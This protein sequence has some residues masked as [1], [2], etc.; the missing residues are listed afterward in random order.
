M[1]KSAVMQS[2]NWIVLGL[3]LAFTGLLAAPA[4]AQMYPG[5]VQVYSN[6]DQYAMVSGHLQVTVDRTSVPVAW[7]YE[8]DEGWE[9]SEDPDGDGLTN[10]EEFDGCT[11]T[12]NGVSGVYSYRFD[13][14]A[15]YLGPGSDPQFYDTDG[16]GISD[17]LEVEAV[18]GTHTSPGL[19]DTDGDEIPDAVEMYA[20]L[21]PCRDGCVY[22]EDD[23]TTKE[24]T[25]SY[26]YNYKV[27]TPS[28]MEDEPHTVTLTVKIVDS[29]TPQM[30]TAWDEEAGEM[31]EIGPK[32]TVWHPDFDIDGDGISNK[33][34]LDADS[35]PIKAM[36][37]KY[38]PPPRRT[39]GTE[40]F[41]RSILDAASWTSPV[42][43]DSDG[44]WLVDS[45]ENSSNGLDAKKAE[46]SGSGKHWSE[47][48][49]RDG[50]VT[51]REM[52]LHPLLSGAS[53]GWA[54]AKY[55]DNALAPVTQVR[56]Y[57]T[58]DFG[59]WY[60]PRVGWR[61]S[62]TKVLEGVHGY[63]HDAQ[64]SKPG[65]SARYYDDQGELKGVQGNVFWDAPS[66]YWTAPVSPWPGAADSDGDDLPDGWEVEHGLNPLS[67]EGP[68][69]L[70][71]DPDQDGLVNYEEYWG[72][73][74]H[75]IS[76]VIG[77][78]DETSPWITRGLNYSG[79]SEFED[80]LTREDGVFWFIAR[81]PWQAP[82]K[83]SLGGVDA[84]G[85]ILD[86]PS[87]YSGTNFPGLFQGTPRLKYDKETMTWSEATQ[88]LYTKGTYE[89]T[90]TNESGEVE[91]TNV[92]GLVKQ[93]VANLIP[94]PGVPAPVAMNDNAKLAAIGGYGPYFQSS[95]GEGA[96]QPFATAI[97]NIFYYENPDEKDGR[98]TPG[99]DAVW[100]AGAAIDGVYV[101]LEDN[102][103]LV[104]ADPNGILTGDE[105]GYPLY[106]N[107]PLMMPMPGRDTDN[108]GLPDSME[109]QMDVAKGKNFSSPVSGLNPLV[110]RSA[111]I[112]NTNGMQAAY[113]TDLFIFS[114]QF[115]IEAW[116]FLAG[117]DPAEGTFVRGGLAGG[118]KYAYDL[119][120]K[121]VEI[122]GAVV[123]TVPYIGFHTLGGKWYQV[124]ATRPLPR[125]RWVHLAGTFDPDKNGLS[126][127]IDGLLEQTRSVQEESYSAYL[128]YYMFGMGALLT[129]GQGE[130]FPDR[131]WIDEV[132]VWGVERSSAEIN[133]NMGKLQTGYQTVKLD[134]QDLVGGLMAYYPF[135]DGGNA[136]ADQR[137]RALSSLHMNSYPAQSG[138]ENSLKHEYFYPDMSYGFPTE[139]LGGAFV[140]D[141]GNVAPVSG[142]VDAQQGE[143]DSDGDGLPDSFELQNNMN[144]FSWYTPVHLYAR[145]DE[146][147]GNVNSDLV[148]IER[149]S[150]VR[151]R[152]SKDGGDNW[153]DTTCPY[154]TVVQSGV[155]KKECDP[156]T[157]LI[158]DTET[159]YD[160]VS[161]TNTQ[162]TGTSSWTN[163]SY[164]SETTIGD[165]VTSN[166]VAVG[167]TTNW[168]ITAGMV[169]E[170]EEGSAWWVSTAGSLYAPYSK[171][172]YSRMVSDADG[173]PD[174]D[175]L[176]NLQEYWARTNP[177]KKDT[178]EDGVPDG[179]EDF[180]G[181]GLPNGKESEFGS[182]QDL[183]DTDDDG[184]DD[185]EEVSGGS[186]PA[187]SL[188][189]AQSL[190]VYFDGKPGTWLE[191]S[192]ATKYALDSWTVEAKVL[193][194]G[195]DFLGDGQSASILRR[196]VE[197]V[198]NGMTIA[199]YELRVVRDGDSLYPMARYVY[200]TK[201]G[202]GAAVEL[203][204][205]EPLATVE[206]GEAWDAEKVT[207][208]AV[209]YYGPAKRI[210][211]YVNG[212][213]VAEKSELTVGNARTGEGPAT[214]LRMG[215]GFRGFIDDVRVWSE[216]RKASAIV[217]SMWEAPSGA[218][219]G[220][221]AAFDFNDGG[222]S[223]VL[224]KETIAT[225]R[226]TGILRS[227]K[228]LT[229]IAP[230]D[231]ADG[232][233]WVDGGS[234]W[235]CDAGT[236]YEAG[237][238]ADLGPVFCEG[239]VDGGSAEAGQ[240][241]WSY[242]DQCLYRYDGTQW[243]K[244]GK[245][246]LWLADA[247]SLVK[248]KVASLD[249]IL[250]YD[251][252]PGDQFI[253]TANGMVYIYRA[254]L[255]MDR[256]NGTGDST[257]APL[258][259]ASGYV[260]ELD[261][262]PL[263]PGHRFYLQS[264][265]R[266]VEWDGTDLVTVAN[267]YDAEGLVVKVQSEGMAYKSDAARKYFRMWG[268]VP[269]L[270]DGTVSR[271]WESGWA[272][273][274]RSSGGVQLY[275]TDASTTGY[276]PVSG[277]D[278]DG[279]GLPDEWEQR[280]NLD[281][282]DPGF[283]GTTGDKDVD[284]DGRPDYV[285]NEDD[286]LNGPWGDPDGDGLNNRAEYLAGTNP[287]QFDTD[288][289]GIGDYDSARVAGG[290]TFGSLYM[291]GDDI[292]DGW[293]SLFPSSCSPLRY[294]SNLDPDGD[295]WDNYSEY[296]GVRKTH[297]GSSYE[298]T[299]NSDGTVST[300]V[301]S[302]DGWYV[303][304]C[305]PDDAAV[306]PMPAMD[307]HFKVDCL[308]TGTL[309]IYAYTD[310]AMTCPDAATAYE[311]EAA[312]RDGQALAITDWTEGGHIRQGA[313]YFMA[314]IDENNDGQW[315][316]G[317]LL[318]FSENMPENISWDSATV[319]IALTEKA[320]GYPR[321]SWA[322]AQTT[323]ATSNETA[324][325]STSAGDAATFYFKQN[326]S[327][328][329]T[330]ELAGCGA[331]R[332]FMHEWD[333]IAQPAITAPLRGLY[334]WNLVPKGASDSSA[335]GT[336]D[337]RN[338]ATELV[339]PV[340]HNPVGT[341]FYAKARM[342][343]T[344]DR[345]ITTLRVV[346]KNAAG[347]VI[348]D[349]TIPAPYVDRNNRA[350]IDFPQLLGWGSLT[351]GVY[352]LQVTESNPAAKSTSDAVTFTVALDSPLK[353][354]AA[355]V[356]GT[357]EYFGY[358]EGDAR[359]IVVE[360]FGSAGFD[361]KPIARTLAKGDGSYRLMG[362]PLGDAYVRAFHDQNGN[363]ELD[364]GEAWTLLKGAPDK[365]RAIHWVTAVIRGRA[366]RG[367][368]SKE[369]AVSVY[370]T[371]YSAKNVN[372][373]AIRDYAG[374]DMVLHD[375]DSDADGLPD[376]WELYYAGNL[377][378]MNQY[379]DLDK[380]GLPDKDE[381]VANTD[382]SKSDSDGDGLTDAEEV[383]TLH[384]NPLS[385]DSDGD[386]LTDAEE[387]QQYGT[388][389]N[390]EDSDGDGISDADE[391]KGVSGFVTDPLSADTDGD[392]MGDGAEV[393]NGYDPT[394]PA[395][396][397]A[398][399]DEDGL[400]NAEEL[401]IGT[402]PKNADSDGDGYLDG[403]DPAPLDPNDPS[404]SPVTFKSAPTV[405]NA[406]NEFEVEVA[407]AAAPLNVEVQSAT[408]LVNGP[409]WVT[410]TNLTLPVVTDSQVILVP[411]VGEGPIRLFRIRVTP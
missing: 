138:V 229:A 308:K 137:H 23:Y 66:A 164:S 319:N 51:L 236:A 356:S 403:V 268:S 312:L 191:V 303:P 99:V 250:S 179:E 130:D 33:G 4:T 394:D 228:S 36:A 206:E 234:V 323:A 76:R 252:T 120:V 322:G 111:R 383:Q 196:G 244:W 113:A 102:G 336:A 246:P 136:A 399:D 384:T 16:D 242:V 201:A 338:Y 261:A 277:Q 152:A 112:I 306:Y 68:S 296:M 90:V 222:W 309:R 6:Y 208:L 18:G 398:D 73:D 381:L 96:F 375:A 337:L 123:D 393:D 200:K 361:Q 45:F 372:L 132:R 351:N 171:V 20:G 22:T 397:A 182:R 240:F 69:G 255:P 163:D 184:Y 203:R 226:Y 315:N 50:L 241:G 122:G 86:L 243:L 391:V 331:T 305:L 77:T 343:M 339:K 17:G 54:G 262:D 13:P 144:P 24:E 352:T 265:E 329:F 14:T 41:P 239:T 314:F 95:G 29:M 103:D 313:N 280:Y 373:K 101:G 149:L 291:D 2:T 88:T 210:R 286:F 48:P 256:P 366:A 49:D 15:L 216:E 215:E 327:V 31:V 402:D 79:K 173:D 396:G 82:S 65:D 272:D 26:T 140:F 133:A 128:Q 301:T 87:V 59:A 115:T 340:I 333:F 347:A 94:V 34:E 118:D 148:I 155:I 53:V 354:G 334:T 245:T 106:D 92:T 127:Y 202:T 358:A 175:G 335:S 271:G 188:D 332:Q 32:M 254:T 355:M 235:V 387:V 407:V 363:G 63:L 125:G 237:T 43:C 283:G 275:R 81:E 409:N 225:D 145:Y 174:G 154:V 60:N 341:M 311:L 220:L 161:Q 91:T 274:A 279:D 58:S 172:G 251:P 348:Y 368:V 9:P 42:N 269:T 266:I 270:E 316:D 295:G 377:T 365:A 290:A 367:G 408:N 89:A 168:C 267:A 1:K 292:P 78:G 285:Y 72:Q 310:K 325:A 401:K 57:V 289:D 105:Q 344:L 248:A 37:E 359:R 297:S 230:E 378:A 349:E 84:E 46:E 187:S 160:W 264:Q 389:P 227:V 214:I 47:D 139:K 362:L 3:A 143:Y 260:A 388:D 211:L 150:E 410:A 221:A 259:P 40:D 67:A 302:R 157:V 110:S 8:Y 70:M 219:P 28:G 177:Y 374:N 83:F 35:G 298:V 207:H 249:E 85:N 195:H 321:I 129:V 56:P 64:Y 183:A 98:Y 299:T 307:F 178:D 185:F 346:A 7:T 392:G 278:T 27:V 121:P 80:F 62:G 119:G 231:M 170:I 300:N 213:K 190:A 25:V 153:T 411:A 276:V 282:N 146:A 166:K 223:G 205:S 293:E 364:P 169:D 330:K 324:S 304:Y 135:D 176:T 193:P 116:V 376:A 147:W 350:E 165:V 281:P 194:A 197:D 108:D 400:T 131:L 404:G 107:I 232:D 142:A 11:A 287:R 180:E 258:D 44:D 382:P 385:A 61:F 257:L 74:G 104:L 93:E 253:D 158:E 97:G 12:V 218:E 353:S 342:I 159:A 52:C 21:D 126:L 379:S 19:K 380:D 151:W 186:S 386:G 10:R 198:K 284:G 109:I 371:D 199:N 360:A 390:K 71:G 204:G 212:E 117:T 326:G 141:S 30:E 134:K 294:D 189:P 224:S 217:D 288:N 395:D 156:S 233:T 273:A 320:H 209:T 370:A 318:G 345:D 75:R 369:D 114:R 405:P 167:T 238:V 162:L 328:M 192:D 38:L 124:S 55:I 406:Q 247:R 357:V 100:F 263:K 317:E 5:A 181:D 39:A